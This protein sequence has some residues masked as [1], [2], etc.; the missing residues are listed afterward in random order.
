MNDVALAPEDSATASQPAAISARELTV[1]YDGAPVLDRLEL[2]LPAGRVSAL[3]GP[4]GS[5]KST[6]LKAC[7]GLLRA[8]GGGVWLGDRPLRALGP[9]AL[10]REVA[11]LP[12]HPVVPD[13][14]TVAEVVALG[15]YP[16]RRWLARASEADRRA[17]DEAMAAAGVTGFADRR[18]ETLSG[19]ERQR[20]WLA[21]TLAQESRI[22][23]LDEPTTFLDPQHQVA[24]LSLVR[25]VARRRGLTVVWVLH[26]L[27]HAA[28][29]SDHLVLFREGAVATAGDPASVLTEANVRHTFGLETVIVPHPETGHPLCVPRM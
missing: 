16:Y 13:G 1:A 21:L 24:M 4:N 5:G 14:L 19:G 28:G 22:L 25:D 10:A 6:L 8:G 18:I 27:N 3:C 20:A 9:R 15:R 12:Q 17:V 23:L 26:D 2:D 7:A 11:L 29:W